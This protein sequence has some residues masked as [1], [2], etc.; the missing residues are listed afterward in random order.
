MNIVFYVS[1]LFC[2]VV[3][4]S[5]NLEKYLLA[6]GP[7]HTSLLET[8]FVAA[9]GG[10]RKKKVLDADCDSVQSHSDVIEN[11]CHEH[12][13]KTLVDLVK[14]LTKVANSDTRLISKLAHLNQT[15][16]GT[17]DDLQQLG[18]F[19]RINASSYGVDVLV[20]QERIFAKKIRSLFNVTNAVYDTQWT[21]LLTTINKLANWTQEFTMNDFI[22][23]LE[24]GMNTA[25]M[26]QDDM[27]H[28]FA[29]RLS[30][31]TANANHWITG[32]AQ[33]VNQ[34]RQQMATKIAASTD[35]Q[36]ANYKKQTANA[37]SA[38]DKLDDVTDF[39]LHQA[40]QLMSKYI[41]QYRLDGVAAARAANSAFT[42]SAAVPPEEWKRI[43][44]VFEQGSHASLTQAQKAWVQTE[45]VRL[46]NFG[47]TFK[48]FT[49]TNAN[50][51][52]DTKLSDAQD[53]AQMSDL[54]NN[55]T[56]TL[57]SYVYAA[58]DAVD[59]ST[60]AVEALKDQTT[61]ANTNIKDAMAALLTQLSD[62]TGD[63]QVK[64]SNFLKLASDSDANQLAALV[65]SASDMRASLSDS[66]AGMRADLDNLI[67]NLQVKLA[68]KAES[69]GNVSLDVQNALTSGSATAAA[70]LRATSD[71]FAMV[72]AQ[73]AADAEDAAS[74]VLAD[75]WNSTVAAAFGFGN[76]RSD[77]DGVAKSS[78][79]FV[80]SQSD[81]TAAEAKNAI[82]ALQ[83]LAGSQTRSGLA[84]SS[85]A[86][87]AARAILDSLSGVQSG[88]LSVSAALADRD[89]STSSKLAAIA[90]QLGMTDENVRE[91]YA[92]LLKSAGASADSQIGA[93][94][95][96]QLATA[97]AQ[98]SKTQNSVEQSAGDI[99]QAQASTALVEQQAIAVD[100]KFRSQ[101]GSVASSLDSQFADRLARD[102][103]IRIAVSDGLASTR[104]ELFVEASKAVNAVSNSRQAYMNSMLD[105]MDKDIVSFQGDVSG[106]S[107]SQFNRVNGVMVDLDQARSLRENADAKLTQTTDAYASYVQ[108]ANRRIGVESQMLDA[109]EKTF[110][111]KASHVWSL[112]APELSDLTDLEKSETDLNVLIKS[113]PEKISTQMKIIQDSFLLTDSQIAE[114]AKILQSMAN[115]ATSDEQ[116]AEINQKLSTLGKSAALMANFKEVERQAL[117]Q[118]FAKNSGLLGTAKG[119]V[120]NLT[121]VANSISVMLNSNS[122]L[123]TQIDQS[124]ANTLSDVNSM[125][126]QMNNALAGTN[127]TLSRSIATASSEADFSSSIT[128]GQVGSLIQS[129]QKDAFLAQTVVSDVANA[130]DLTIREK[131]QQLKAYAAV[132]EQ[133]RDHLIQQATDVMRSANDSDAG[134][135]QK[136]AENAAEKASQLIIV[137]N[138]VEQLLQTWKQYTDA[139]NRKFMRWNATEDEYVGQFLGSMSALN[140]SAMTVVTK[141]T[142]GI[143]QT[144]TSSQTAITGFVDFENRMNAAN[145]QVRAAVNALN[146]SSGNS[147]QQVGEQIYQE[148]L[149]D[150]NYD[151]QARYVAT[152]DMVI[153]S[154]K[155]DAQMGDIL[156][157]LKAGSVSSFIDET[158]DDNDELRA[159]VEELDRQ[160]QAYKE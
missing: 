12:R 150:A 138:A 100:A 72:K 118:V 108:E 142:S 148:D 11:T 16:N 17:T 43:Q 61:K 70:K 94:V 96:A 6:L 51:V 155:A 140:Q 117:N 54:V 18:V 106:L 67:T 131:Q 64:I 5:V 37:N 91:M 92:K 86:Q 36:A 82:V 81:L 90:T 84:S 66:Q 8:E 139:E 153:A 30:S 124:L 47:Q 120:G 74:G 62:G 105:S 10:K 98:A 78:R 101:L 121:D 123:N 14:N 116:R 41:D 80:T 99:D 26:A 52:A 122:Q 141:T 39:F 3:G 130:S 75:V 21:N 24:N 28:L 22:F 147:I 60:A 113:V 137:K 76:I 143:S 133:N 40:P 88:A 73:A 44:A 135:R 56:D 1:F 129:G 115:S 112:G 152:R 151:N 25:Q 50:A 83:Q 59:K 134:L 144:D 110:A 15:T 69:E 103:A 104:N 102:S 146:I 32:L 57:N 107:K 68:Q 23:Q 58:S 31:T 125:S 13:Y 160:V 2:C 128:N 77:M 93:V 111:D 35:L 114:K 89:G 27:A 156:A 7:S 38:S 132:L 136:V 145:E 109:D 42:S 119:S 63:Q 95:A 127:S 48:K 29:S 71:Y 85:D 4:R 149:K 154:N 126:G 20:D 19:Q 45:T 65:Q 33:M 79:D 34:F 9:S 157:S 49:Q 97:K 158:T 159:Q 53:M 55:M 46:A 87:A